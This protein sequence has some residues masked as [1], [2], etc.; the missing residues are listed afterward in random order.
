MPRL[1]PAGERLLA[2]FALRQLYGEWTH[3][4]YPNWDTALG[5]RRWHLQRYWPLAATGLLAAAT[6][7]ILLSPQQRRTAVF[8]LDAALDTY[9]RWLRA[10]SAGPTAFGIA[11]PSARASDRKLI[12]S[13]WA[14]IAARAATAGLPAEDAPAAPAW[15]AL[16]PDI[17]RLAVSTARYWTAISPITPVGYGGAELARLHATSTGRPVSGTGGRGEAAFGVRIQRAGRKL[18][19]TQAATRRRPPLR[20]RLDRPALRGTFSRL[21]ART[22]LRR[23]GVRVAVRHEFRISSIRTIRVIRVKR[24]ATA[25]LRFPI[26]GDGPVRLGRVSDLGGYRVRLQAIPAGARVELVSVAS[27]P[28]SP[29]TTRVL[30]VR[31]HLPARRAVR[32]VETVLVP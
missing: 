1:D 24:G 15:F 22:T 27:Q 11:S 4:G 31:F 6:D 8:E 32:T 7:R 28:S 12:D 16:D 26:W 10:G 25:I 3:A 20:W 2:G 23:P 13:R 9:E 5:Y 29:E 19:D 30:T 21:A 14:V 17:G 18:L